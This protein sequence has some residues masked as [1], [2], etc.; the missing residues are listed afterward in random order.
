VDPGGRDVRVV[1]ME[2]NKAWNFGSG[3]GMEV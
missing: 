2:G 3:E 1:Y